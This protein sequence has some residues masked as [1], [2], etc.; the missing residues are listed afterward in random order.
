[1]AAGSLS[2]RLQLRPC[3]IER[4][5]AADVRHGCGDQKQMPDAAVSGPFMLC[6][7]TACEC[8]RRLPSLSQ[9]G[10][11]KAGGGGDHL[12]D[13]ADGSNG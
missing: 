1:M 2:R 3:G 4:R 11:R 9:G 5:L 13:S 12:P 10:A 6:V 7:R 8:V